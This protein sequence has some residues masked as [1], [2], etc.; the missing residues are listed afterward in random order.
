MRAVAIVQARL[1]SSRLPAK[2]MLDLAGTTALGR[3][4]LRVRKVAGVDEVVV[5]TSVDP[6]D[7]VLVHACTRLGVRCVRGSLDDVL[8]RFLTAARATDAS[9]VLRFT[10]D[11]PLIDPAV[12]SRVL[13]RFHASGAD[14]VSNVR[15]RRFPRGLDTEVF[16]RQALERAHAVATGA[17]REH[18]TMRMY[19]DP[20]FRCEGVLP[21]DDRDLSHLRWT[22]DTLDDYRAL[23]GIFDALGERG[24]AADYREVAALCESRP[25]LAAANAHIRQKAV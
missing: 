16:S 24:D 14:Y 17:E 1:S 10:S 5:G 3:C 8:D 23:Y 22:L 13:A 6:S 15:E 9:T 12:S 11:C 25:E 4:L 2:V 19:Q 18:V 21:E 20:S 7:D